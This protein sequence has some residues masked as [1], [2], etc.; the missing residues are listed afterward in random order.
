[1]PRIMTVSNRSVAV[2]CAAM[3]AVLA[4]CQAGSSDPGRSGDAG[5]PSAEA[6]AGWVTERVDVGGHELNSYCKGAG[7]PT[8]VFENGLGA[9]LGTWFHSVANAFPSVRTC[10]YDRVNTGAS[11][12]VPGRHTGQDSVHDLHGLLDVVAVP[13][14]YLLV[15]HS[16]GGLLSAMYAGS[17]PTDVVGLV[18]LDPTLPTHADM[19][20]P[21]PERDRAVVAAELEAN[22]ENVEF[23]AALE[24]AKT[25]VPKI[26]NIP[27]VVIGSTKL[28]DMP[29]AWPA[30]D[31]LAARK[32]SLQ[33]FIEAIP[34]GELRY[35]DSGHMIQR[36][37]PQ[38]VIDEIRRLME[39]VR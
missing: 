31:M 22:A 6:A 9:N 1:V 16:F 36:D 29:P 4:G 11:D 34:Q 8:I 30:E 27:V 35:V 7:S 39:T 26:S 21:L 18:L 33:D 13:P 5:T 32:R 25:L 38:L 20:K 2:W 14:P 10:V 12:R 37:A 24:Q 3:T 15:G 19:F 23:F 17:Y 28:G